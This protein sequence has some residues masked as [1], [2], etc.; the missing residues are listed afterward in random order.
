MLIE[1]SMIYDTQLLCINN[2]S[3]RLDCPFHYHSYHILD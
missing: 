2:K 3:I 1:Y